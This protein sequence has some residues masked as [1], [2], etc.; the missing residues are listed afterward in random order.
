MHTF[1]QHNAAKI[2]EAIKY[3]VEQGLPLSE[4]VFRRESSMF[5]EYFLYLRENQSTVK[6]DCLGM[7]LV[8]SDIGRFGEYEGEKVPLDL[9]FITEEEDDV[10]LGKPKRGGPKKF[11][12]YV[13]NPKTGNVKK[14][15]F[16]DTT[17][18][19]AK[20]NDPKARKAY[21]ARHNCDQAKDRTTAQYWSCNLPR[22]AKAL[23]LSG[24][25]NF[26]W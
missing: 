2:Q 12:V 23:G 10:E 5:Y 4:C 1:K 18:L 24:G 9:P 7:V 22:Y 3:N 19:K 14:V 8:E 13:R 11:Y 21:A 20:I 15:T 6:L 26:F 17:G 25:G 16:G